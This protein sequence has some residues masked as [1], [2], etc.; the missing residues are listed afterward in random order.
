MKQ[1]KRGQIVKFH[2]P[3]IDE[4]PEQ[5]YVVL[6][7]FEDED[8]SRA[9]I[10]PLKTGLSIPGTL[11]VFSKDIEIDALQTFQLEYYLEFGKHDF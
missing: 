11:K 1:I 6:E 7:F 8:K 4:N 9:L 10:R 3:N 2:T 5:L